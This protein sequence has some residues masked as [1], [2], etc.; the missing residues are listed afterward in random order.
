MAGSVSVSSIF[1]CM[2]CGTTDSSTIPI[3]TYPIATNCDPAATVDNGSCITTVVGCADPLALNY[4]PTANWDIWTNT[5]V[6]H[7]NACQYNGCTDPTANNYDP[8]A[9][10]ND[11]TCSYPVIGCMNIMSTNY[12]I[13]NDTPCD[14]VNDL[15][16]PCVAD[17][18]GTMQTITSSPLGCCL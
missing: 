8:N 13:S 4:D 6:L 14:G 9:N 2:D 11:G 3:Y 18:S 17:A 1:G 15:L 7:P 5:G 12:N 10:Y 16:Q